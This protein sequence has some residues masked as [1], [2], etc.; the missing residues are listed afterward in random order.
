MNAGV[1]D[2]FF[3]ITNDH[4]SETYPEGVV[5]KALEC[6]TRASECLILLG[7]Q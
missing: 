2:P 6:L 5:L 7:R 4:D 3:L 1:S